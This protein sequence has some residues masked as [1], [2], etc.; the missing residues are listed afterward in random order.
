MGSVNRLFFGIKHGEDVR[1]ISHVFDVGRAYDSVKKWIYRRGS[2]MACGC[3]CGI[4]VVCFAICS[5]VCFG[6]L[7]CQEIDCYMSNK[8]I[9]LG[10]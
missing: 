5:Y 7:E 8:M 10:K 3:I 4:M 1:Q 6:H 9:T 2:L